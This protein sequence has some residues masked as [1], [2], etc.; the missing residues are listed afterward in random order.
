MAIIFNEW[1]ARFAANPKEFTDILGPDGKP[2]PDY[3]DACAYYF[4]R[5]AW[6]LDSQGKLPKPL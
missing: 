3:G 6:E 5:L 4:E 2:V 1:A